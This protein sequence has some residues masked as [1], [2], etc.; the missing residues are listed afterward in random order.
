MGQAIAAGAAARRRTAPNPWVGSVIVRDGAVVGIGA[1]EP[2]GGA[3]AEV[4]AL[5]RA[6]ARARGGT[7]YVTLEPCVHAGRT[8]PC[9]DALL[10]AGVGR[11]VVAIEDPDPRVAGRG[12]ARL[13]AAGLAVDVGVGA[14]QAAR[15]LAPY[16]HHR[17]TG[18]AF[19]VVKTATSLDGRTA[20]ADG[21]SQWITGAEARADA[22]ELRADSQALLV[23]A[24]TALAD[25][26]RL[27][28]R[29]AP[30]SVAPAQ[31][32]VRVLLDAVGRV[33]ARGSL[34]DV[35][36][37][38]TTVMT[39]AAAPAEAVDAWRAAGAKVHVVAGGPRGGV[40]PTAV[41][42]HLAADG[43]LQALAEG[44]A[45]VHGSIVAAGLA[46]RVVQ[47]VGGA[48]LGPGGLA[49]IGEPGPA[50]LADATRWRLVD[51]RAL[52]DDARL[53]WD[54]QPEER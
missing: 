35:A 24:G 23:G 17:R 14:A 7:A 16:L 28:V 5:A 33:P 44:G 45:S 12:L 39:S 38:P 34:F 31:P 36:L 51:A 54:P 46:G 37:A 2:P 18:R 11:V 26:P 49:A 40:D 53:E 47:Y 13:R 15:V 52:G 42:E 27:T 9:A 19:A 48:I 3:H 22:H 6:G 32:P 41:L 10:R 20:A 1:T 29:T 8:G 30:G 50:T 4:V 25:R 43:V 21:S